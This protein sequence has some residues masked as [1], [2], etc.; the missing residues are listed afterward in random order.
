MARRQA[1]WVRGWVLAA[2]THLLVNFSLLRHRFQTRK[3]D[4]N[5][6]TKTSPKAPPKMGHSRRKLVGGVAAPKGRS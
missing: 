5:P 4:T 2:Q 6:S 1:G 3:P